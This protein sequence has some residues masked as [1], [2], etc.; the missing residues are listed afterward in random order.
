MTAAVDPC[1]CIDI[2]GL[3]VQLALFDFS[4]VNQGKKY[5]TCLKKVHIF[6]FDHSQMYE[7]NLTET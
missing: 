7:G 5:E 1:L 2:L 6:I 3:H 4:N